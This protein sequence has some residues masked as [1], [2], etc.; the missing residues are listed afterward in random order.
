MGF[1]WK[2]F[3]P[4]FIKEILMVSD[5]DELMKKNLDYSLKNGDD[6]SLISTRNNSTLICH[7]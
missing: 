6:D 3:Y 7:C 2:N 1:T 4:Q 5:L